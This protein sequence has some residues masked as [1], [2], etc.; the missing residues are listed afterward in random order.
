MTNP[1]APRQVLRLACLLII[2]KIGGF[3]GLLAE[4]P[5]IAWD[6][7][8]ACAWPTPSERASCS[9]NHPTHRTLLQLYLALIQFLHS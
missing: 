9:T 3:Y 5:G 8:K 2:G 1:K 6:Q 7:M 4:V